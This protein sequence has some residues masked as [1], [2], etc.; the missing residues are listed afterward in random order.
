MPEERMIKNGWRG[1]RQEYFCS[2]A[3]LV[4]YCGKGRQATGPSPSVCWGKRQ[5]AG[6]LRQPSAG[7]RIS[8]GEETLAGFMENPRSSIPGTKVIFAD[9]QEGERGGLTAYFKKATNE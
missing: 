7:K 3:C 4:L 9:I 8:W 6:P 5:P 1:E 2:E